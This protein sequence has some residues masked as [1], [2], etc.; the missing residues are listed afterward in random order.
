MVSS[1]AKKSSSGYLAS[2][3]ESNLSRQ[4]EHLQLHD[5][6][7]AIAALHK[8]IIDRFPSQHVHPRQP[9]DEQVS[10]KFNS[11]EQL[12]S[13]RWIAPRYRFTRPCRRWYFPSEQNMSRTGWNFRLGRTLHHM[14]TDLSSSPVVHESAGATLDCTNPVYRADLRHI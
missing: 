2:N 6:N 14:S 9:H 11:T 4:R 3:K 7:R 12:P 13:T 5:H 8:S 10:V 1:L